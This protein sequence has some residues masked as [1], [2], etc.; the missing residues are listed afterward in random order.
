M[1]KLAFRLIAALTVLAGIAPLTAQ[2]R[3][4]AVII[5]SSN[6][7]TPRELYGVS[8]I[9]AALAN[10]NGIE[11]A[12]STILVGVRSSEIFTSMGTLSKFTP[13]ET[14]AF[15]LLRYGNKWLVIGSDPSG[16]LYGSL[17]LAH[18]IDAARGLPATI[19]VIDKP[20]FKIRGTC[21]LWMKYGNG[22]YNWPV[23]PQNFPWFYDRKLML[24]YLDDL[25]E[26]RYNAIVFWNAH[27]FPYFLTLPKYPEARM[28]N[29]AELQRNMDQLKWFTE[30]ADRRGIWTVVHFYNIHVSPT[31]AKA[32]AHEGVKVE[33]SA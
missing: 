5:V 7:A 8:R 31:F 1:N 30:E 24:Q 22:F 14:E 18:R 26:N 32:H 10:V 20:A 33:N 4:P 2:S 19:D 17:E 12:G 29:D 28:F 27:P 16:V 13:G 11:S 23:T 3:R 15:H 9:R 6:D 25:A 21:L